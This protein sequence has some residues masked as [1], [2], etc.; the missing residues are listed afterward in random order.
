MAK[1]AIQKKHLHVAHQLPHRTRLKLAKEHRT[2]A[3]MKEVHQALSKVPG[4]H[5]VDVNERTGSVTLHHAPSTEMIGTIAEAVEAIEGFEGFGAMEGIA[6]TITAV[7]TFELAGIA[8]LVPLAIS[9][10]WNFVGQ[11]TKAKGKEKGKKHGVVHHVHGRSRLKLPHTHRTQENMQKVHDA[12]SKVKGVHKVEMNHRTGS[13]TI[14]HDSSPQTMKAADKAIKE[15]AS[16]IF[17]LLVKG[18][19]FRTVGL[20]VFA[21]LVLDDPQDKEAVLAD[22]A[23][24]ATLG[25]ISFWILR[26]P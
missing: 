10:V 12:L 20:G 2:A 6:E 7:E 25:L 14:H 13:I 24:L 11:V 23:K 22:A 17:D 16:E 19:D 26:R 9:I 3:R 21:H 5:Q 15:A 1:T 18:E 4:V 8:M